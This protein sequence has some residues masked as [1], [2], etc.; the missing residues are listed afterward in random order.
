M[1]V[2]YLYAK[3]WTEM[4]KK[5]TTIGSYNFMITSPA[6]LSDCPWSPLYA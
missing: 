2:D 5:R 6:M 3:I 4:A 1:N